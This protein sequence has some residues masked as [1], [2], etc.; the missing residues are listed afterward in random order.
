MEQLKITILGCG[1]SGGV[2]A[3]GNNWG[4]C[5]PNEPKNNRT[6]ASIAIQSKETN[7]IVDTGPDFRLQMNR[8]NIEDL[9][10]I[11]YTHA[12]ADHIAGIDDLRSI[13]RR[14]KKSM[15]AYGNQATLDELQDRFGYMFKD[16]N[17]LYLKV[18]DAFILSEND[19][20]KTMQIGDIEL[21]PF[22]QDHASCKTLGFRF[23]N[24]AYSTDMI[25][26][27]DASIEALQ[28]IDT[29][30]I[31]GAGYFGNPITAHANINRVQELNE[32]VGAANIYLT[33]LSLMMDYNDMLEKLPD[34]MLPCY[35]GMEFLV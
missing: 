7:L 34:G 18:L 16:V 32:K 5:D 33:H 2:P 14:Y 25:D 13:Q 17:S 11:L 3:V 22:E 24:L 35:D 31:D 9:D 21:T 6:R 29:W 23:K 28:G 8:A 20:G 1:A 27:N 4:K 10:A 12:H 15:P 19:F 30:I 26:L